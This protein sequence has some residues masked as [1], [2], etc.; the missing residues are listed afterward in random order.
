MTNVRPLDDP[1]TGAESGAT[2][3]GLAVAVVARRLGVAPATLRTWDR[4]YG[5]GP[6]EHSAGAHR[7]YSDDDVARLMVMRRLALDGVAPVDAA[8]SALALDLSSTTRERVEAEL[9]ESLALADSEAQPGHDTPAGI[10]VEPQKPD[11]RGAVPGIA[12]V[13]PLRPVRTDT[14]ERPALRLA[15]PVATPEITSSDI[16]DAVLRGNL[17]TCVRLLT[18][19][20]D[21]DPAEWWTTLVEPT[22]RRLSARTVLAKPGEAPEVLL[23]SATLTVLGDFIRER[24][25]R[26]DV[27]SGGSA[28][29][30]SRMRK[31]VLL[32]S[33]VDD[34][35]PLAMHALGAALVAQGVTARVVTGPSNAHRAMELVTMVRPVA[36]VLVTSLTRPELGIV[37]ALHDAQPDLP[38]FVGL[39]SDDAAAD[40]PLAANVSRVR[41]FH[42]L[43]HEVLAISR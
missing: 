24:E 1:H 23:A 16:V 17:S 3:P 39:S 31:I 2:S 13:A 10:E 33:A 15:A 35:Q 25:A 32:F 43:L 28:S 21:Q 18:L 9:R 19:E 42:G 11:P 40:L 34:P 30:P 41:S 27:E 26:A 20:A 12:G 22:V 37:H 6:S 8:R 29:H 7:R 5:L 14:P 4:R 38:I 36:T